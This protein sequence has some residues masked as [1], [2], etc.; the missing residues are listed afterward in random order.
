M[1]NKRLLNVVDKLERRLDAY[2]NNQ[3]RSYNG[4]QNNR[5]IR[6]NYRDRGSNSRRSSVR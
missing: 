6:S 2:E 3:D 1:E 5:N 4:Y